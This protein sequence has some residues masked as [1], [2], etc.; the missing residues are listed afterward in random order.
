MSVTLS[1]NAFD[2][3][4]DEGAGAVERGKR[5]RITGFRHTSTR[6]SSATLWS[7]DTCPIAKPDKDPERPLA[8]CCRSPEPLSQVI[9]RQAQDEA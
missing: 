7:E 2:S 6:S 1:R 8:G 4:S 3:N 5:V 9:L